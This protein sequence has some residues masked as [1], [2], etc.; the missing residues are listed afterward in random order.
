MIENPEI[1]WT[2][3]EDKKIL[4][5]KFRLPPGG[6][7]EYRRLEDKSGDF[8]FIDV[9]NEYYH[10]VGRDKNDGIRR[11][12]RSKGCLGKIEIIGAIAEDFQLRIT[13]CKENEQ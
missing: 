6:Y 10:S 3:G 9:L 1:V 12:M 13:G 5:A 4:F 7:V 11:L 2:D 8:I